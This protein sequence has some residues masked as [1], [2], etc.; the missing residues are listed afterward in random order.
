LGSKCFKPTPYITWD[1]TK[2]ALG[3]D[4]VAPGIGQEL[5]FMVLM[6]LVYQLILILLE[7]EILQKLFAMIFRTSESVFDANITDEDVLAESQRVANMITDSK[8]NLK[9]FN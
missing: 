2:H 9:V 4:I 7:Y 8:C 6:A 1:Y 3:N 5:L